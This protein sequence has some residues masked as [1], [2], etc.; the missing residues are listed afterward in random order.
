[1]SEN[2][3]QSV[4]ALAALFEAQSLNFAGTP[5]GEAF[6]WAAQKTESILREDTSRKLGELELDPETFR[7][8]DEAFG[9][10]RVRAYYWINSPNVLLH[11]NTPK[12]VMSEDTEEDRSGLLLVLSIL[13]YSILRDKKNRTDLLV[14]A[15]QVNVFDLEVD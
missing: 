13:R 8:F 14:D 2:L 15:Q 10:D 3:E 11:G 6:N 7:L 12:E 5:A 9:E 1:M 4:E